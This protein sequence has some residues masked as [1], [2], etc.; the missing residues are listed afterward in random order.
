M[1]LKKG[2]YMKIF[3]M[4]T[5]TGAVQSR[6]SCIILDY[7]RMW[8]SHLRNVIIP[9]VRHKHPGQRTE[10]KMPRTALMF[11][12]IERRCSPLVI[13][14][15]SWPARLGPRQPAI[16]YCPLSITNRRGAPIVGRIGRPLS[17]S[18]SGI[19]AVGRRARARPNRDFE[20]N[21]DELCR[22]DQ[23]I[24]P[25]TE[26]YPAILMLPAG[27]LPGSA[28]THWYQDCAQREVKQGAHP[29]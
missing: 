3:M 15:N 13:R 5:S 9:H 26:A 10:M 24:D 29:L 25:G 4:L 17:E 1:V 8:P 6:E 23:T 18:R 7:S 16:S 11:W 28:S 20:W 22:E 14:P 21:V 2:K 27:W 19:Q 12:P